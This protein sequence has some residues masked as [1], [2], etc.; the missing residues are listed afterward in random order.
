[1][2][3]LPVP[4]VLLN[5][6]YYLYVTFQVVAEASGPFTCII[7]FYIGFKIRCFGLC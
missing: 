7:T 3:M 5:E 4:I 2:T 1:M 6:D